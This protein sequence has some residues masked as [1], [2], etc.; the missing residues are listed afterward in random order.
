M[1]ADQV[2]STSNSLALGSPGNASTAAAEAT[3]A[4]ASAAAANPGHITLSLFHEGKKTVA[5]MSATT[6]LGEAVYHWAHDK[7][8]D[9]RTVLLKHDSD[10]DYISSDV[11]FEPLGELRFVNNN[12]LLLEVMVNSLDLVSSASVGFPFCGVSAFP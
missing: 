3:N 9:A 7:N 5:H 1:Q 10:D 12:S 11:W 2:D 8:I 4:A 6:T